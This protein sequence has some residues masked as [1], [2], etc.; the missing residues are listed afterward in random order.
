VKKELEKLKNRNN[1]K[2]KLEKIKKS[3]KLEIIGKVRYN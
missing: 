3:K 1:W 2:K